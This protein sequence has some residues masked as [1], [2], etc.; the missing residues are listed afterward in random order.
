MQA[1]E[2]T[3][4][5][6][7]GGKDK[8]TGGKGDDYL[9]GGGQGDV[10]KGNRGN[11]IFAVRRDG[12]VIIKDFNNETDFIDIIGASLSSISIETFKKDTYILNQDGYWMAKLKGAPYLSDEVFL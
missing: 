2:T 10:L 3:I 5:L 11:D 6:G 4:F 7:G 12:S 1:T 8:I 9:D